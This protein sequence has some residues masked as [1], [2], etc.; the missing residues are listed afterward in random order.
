MAAPTP[1]GSMAVQATIFWTAAP[2]S[3][4]WRGGAGNDFYV[5][6]TIG[7]V[8]IE[9]AG[10]G[11]DTVLSFLNSYKLGDN[12]ENLTSFATG[13]FIGI[14]NDLANVIQTGAGKDAIGGRG[15]NDVLISGSGDDQLHGEDGNDVLDGGAG[16]D[17]F[18]GGDGFDTISFASADK[19]VRFALDWTFAG[20]GDAEGDNQQGVE[21]VAGSNFDDV[22]R[23]DGGINKLEGRGGADLLAGGDGND[24]VVGG[25]GKDIL[26]GGAG[27]DRFDYLALSD[28]G[29]TIRD[30]RNATGNNDA[31]RFD[32]DVFGG[33]AKGALAAKHFV[34]N[35]TGVA[36]TIDQHFIYETDTG[37]LRYDANGSAAG[38]VTVIATLTGAPGLS[39]GDFSII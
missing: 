16:R 4:P 18:E 12:F 31:L 22:L 36:A 11:T 26:N 20:T 34:A 28:G 6:D 19:G 39:A 1:T 32:G 25:A 21:A 37:I 5:V 13:D 17:R 10:Q 35:A 7:E 24:V 3:T 30:F 8:V 38:G 9:L 14:G 29:D 2:V 33:L 27:N 23:G 15:G